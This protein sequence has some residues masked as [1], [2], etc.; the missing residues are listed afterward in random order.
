MELK[1]SSSSPGDFAFGAG[2]RIHSLEL[3]EALKLDFEV[4]P[5]VAEN[6]FNGIESACR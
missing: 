6:P 5:A 4:N 1:A 3:K 2:L